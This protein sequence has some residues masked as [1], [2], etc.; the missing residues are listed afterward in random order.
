MTS[1]IFK[2]LLSAALAAVTATP[3]M[4]QY[5]YPAK[6]QSAAT[7]EKD[8]AH[9]TT[10]A[11][12][13]SGFDPRNPPVA[14]TAQAAPVTGSGARVKGAVVG[15]GVGAIAGGDV[16]DAALTGAV[17]GGVARRSS[18]RRAARAQNG[19]NE[20]AVSAGQAAFSQARTACLTG[21]GYTL[22]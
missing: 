8:E 4:A 17:V 20:Q 15:A 6:G 13:Q 16:G 7:Q 3:A 19:A 18:N 9:C 1:Q 2:V 10:W 11:T 21:R 22:K 14:A 12:Q 5:A